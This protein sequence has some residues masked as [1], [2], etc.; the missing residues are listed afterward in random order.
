[1]LNTYAA[2]AGP[3]DPVVVT[4]ATQIRALVHEAMEEFARLHFQRAEAPAT[5]DDWV[6]NK[7]LIRVTGLSKSTLQ[8]HRS[9][10]RLPYHKVGQRVLYRRADVDAFISSAAA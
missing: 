2:H 8:R 5:S 10:G 1:M 3:A 9:S 4:S 6:T 7:E